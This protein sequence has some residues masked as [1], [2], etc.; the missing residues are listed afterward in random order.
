MEKADMAKMQEE[1]AKSMSEFSARFASAWAD[2]LKRAGL[3]TAPDSSSK[4]TAGWSDPSFLFKLVRSPSTVETFQATMKRAADDLPELLNS[5]GDQEKMGRISDRWTRLYEKSVREILGV[6][7]RSETRRLLDQWNAVAR[8]LT[9]ASGA[10]PASSVPPFLGMPTS[11]LGPFSSFQQKQMEV[12]QGLAEAFGASLAPQSYPTD[13]HAKTRA[14]L[15]T[16]IQ[17]LESVPAFQERIWEASK[18]A[19]ENLLKNMEKLEEREITPELLHV[20]S[21]L[22]SSGSQSLFE[23]LFT[24]DSF[25]RTLT[26]MVQQGVDATKKMEDLMNDW[27]TLWTRS[28]QKDME[29]LR[30]KVYSMEKRI[31]LLER[32]VEDLQ[33]QRQDASPN[34]RKMDEAEK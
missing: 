5:M 19:M 7:G 17:F 34:T 12:L 33:G 11:D 32:E 18:K 24:S 9:L 31:R 20:F 1:F 23:E 13:M 6:P 4:T 3:P 21:N 27:A 15:D 14:A 16:Q 26:M 8:S 29:D 28:G 30:Q 25:V 2:T 22:W 10:M